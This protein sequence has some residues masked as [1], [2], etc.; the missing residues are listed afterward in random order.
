MQNAVGG[1]VLMWLIGK[2][3]RT[4]SSVKDTALY[5]FFPAFFVRR[6]CYA[7]LEITVEE[8]AEA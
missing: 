8:T 6:D 1:D 3:I 4:A 7:L 2:Q 5:S